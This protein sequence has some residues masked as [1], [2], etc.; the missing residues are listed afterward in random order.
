MKKIEAVIRIEKLEDVMDALE[1]INC[2]GIMVTRIEGHG[3]QK[4]LKEQFRGREFKVD[5]LPKVKL[6]IVVHDAEVDKIAQCIV[7][8]A[9]TGEIGDGKIFISP[10]ENAIKIRT[11]EKGGD[12]L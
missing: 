12:A 11:G 4:G 8:A 6:D 3:K 1:K 2:P 9:K 10:M 5:L 7:S